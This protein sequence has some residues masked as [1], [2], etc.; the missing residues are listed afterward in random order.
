MRIRAFYDDTPPSVERALC[1]TRHRGSQN[2]TVFRSTAERAKRAEFIGFDVSCDWSGDRSP[3]PAGP[4][5]PRVDLRG[6]FDA[7]LIDRG[8][9]IER[10]K[11]LP[12]HYKGRLLD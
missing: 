10:Q 2:D 1:M 11:P 4:G 9:S 6:L 5:P 12:V 7:E 8:L 3:P